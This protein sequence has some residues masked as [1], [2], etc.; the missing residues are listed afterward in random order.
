MHEKY[1]TLFK[2]LA[3]AT[4][5]LSEQVMEYN[6]SKNDTKGEETAKTMRD[7]YAQLYDRLRSG[8]YQITLKDYAKL[9]VSSY[10]VSENLAS[11]VKNEQVALDGYK[12]D[13]MPKLS[14]IMEET[15]TDEEATKLANEIFQIKEKD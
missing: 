13:I 4:E 6:H 9:L 3:H 2:E 15:K 1:L 14:R 10:I 5:V 8:N 7:D 12:N 11:K